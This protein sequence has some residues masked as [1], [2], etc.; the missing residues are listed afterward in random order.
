MARASDAVLRSA[1]AAFDEAEGRGALDRV[2]GDLFALVGLLGRERRLRSA[3]TDPNL[4]SE[5]KVDLLRALVGDRIDPAALS[6]LGSVF[7]LQRLRPGELAEVLQDVATSALFQ[8]AERAGELEDVEDE[9][10]C[11][12][13]LLEAQPELRAAL[14]DPGVPPER[15]RALVEDLVAG[16]TTRPTTRL[17][18]YLVEQDRARSLTRA[19]EEL[20]ARAAERRDRIVAEVRTAIDLDGERRARLAE[21]LTRVT[22]KRVDLRIVIDPT[23][24]GSL[25]VRVGDEVFDGSVRHQLDLARERLA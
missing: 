7:D 6:V 22:G 5:P 4:P 17:L 25:S 12:A 2:V 16:R 10:F 18:G 19:I 9:L 23:V 1:Q 3:L 15:R 24:V 8:G 14:T 11:F 21:T 20:V 13:R